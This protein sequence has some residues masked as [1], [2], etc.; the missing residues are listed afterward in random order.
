LQVDGANHQGVYS[1][2]SDGERLESFRSKFISGTAFS[3]QING[4]RAPLIYD[5]RDVRSG[6]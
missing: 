6:I 5:I 2:A 3:S 1:E 4:K